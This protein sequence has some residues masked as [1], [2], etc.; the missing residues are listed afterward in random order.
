SDRLAKPIVCIQFFAI[1]RTILTRSFSPINPR[2]RKHRPN[3]LG[4]LSNFVT[5]ERTY[6]AWAIFRRILQEIRSHR[7]AILSL[8]TLGALSAPL[9]LLM[10]LPLKMVLDSVLGPH[11]LPSFL[12]PLVPSW[13]AATPSGILWLAIALMVFISLLQLALRLGT[14]LLQEYLGEKLTLEFRSKLFGHASQLSLAQHDSRGSTDL[15]Y[16][17]QYDAPAIRWLV[18]DGALPFLTA[19]LTLLGMLYVIARLDLALGMIAL[20][21]VPIIF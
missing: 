18:M 4:L 21:A 16:R 10:P 9:A 17:I 15:T 13:I 12:Q 19:L 14:W 6:S 3:Q 8:L 7:M 5:T 2:R 20:L 11:P 1:R